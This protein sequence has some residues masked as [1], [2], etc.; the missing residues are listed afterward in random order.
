[1]KRVII[2]IC[3]ALLLCTFLGTAGATGTDEKKNEF[4]QV[5]Q[6]MVKIRDN[7]SILKENQNKVST[8]IDK[9]GQTIENKEAELQKVKEQLADTQIHLEQTSKELDRAQKD[10]QEQNEMMKKRLR[11]MYMAGSTSYISLLLEAKNFN[12]FLDRYR[13]ISRVALYDRNLLST[14]EQKELVISEKK[15]LLEEEKKSIQVIQQD[16]QQ[17]KQSIEKDKKIKTELL[18]KIVDQKEESEK[19]LEELAAISKQLEKTIQDLQAK[20]AV[21]RKSQQKPVEK[22][23]GGKFA[24]PVPGFYNITS[25]FGF[26]IHPILKIKKMHTGIDIGSSYEGQAKTSIYGTNFTAAADGVVLFAGLMSSLETG[27]GRCVI[28]DHG[29]EIS[30]LYG[31]GSQI[32]VQ[33]GQAVKKG[34]VVLKVGSTGTSTGAHAHFEVRIGGIPTD[35]AAYLK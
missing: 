28:I 8:E 4:N 9:L 6:D 19:D 17:Q 30:T 35:P 3:I 11:A 12:D 23:T 18:G 14:I 2:W 7:I 13:L 10:A 21:K 27:Y 34:Q 32:L 15:G 5:N 24:W 33:E 29:D 31:H 1:M 20:E 22:F 16:I 26:R 25:S